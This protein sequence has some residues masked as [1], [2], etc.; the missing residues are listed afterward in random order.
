MS[1]F[2]PVSEPLI[3]LDDIN[4][5]QKVL[6]EGWASGEG[7]Y[8]SE[9]EDKMSKL[10]KRTQGISVSNGTAAL[11]ILIHSLNLG[12]GDEVILPSFTIISCLTQ[13][14]RSGATPIFVDS[15]AQTW[16]MDVDE[17][18]NSI[19][20]RTKLIIL[21]HIYGLPV[22][23]DPILK[24]AEDLGIPVIEDAAEAHGLTYKGEP[25]GSFGLAS[26]F[27]FFANK[28]ITTGEGG[29]V[30]TN[31]LALGQ[32]LK[33]L[34]N[35]AHHPAQ[36]FS[37]EVL[38]WNLRMTA[39]QCALGTSQLVRLDSILKKRNEIARFYREAFETFDSVQLPLEKT[40]YAVNNYWVF[41]MV[42]SPDKFESSKGIQQSLNE[43]G[44]GSR[45]FFQP[46]H[47]QPLLGHFGLSKQR[48][49]P[50]S[51]YLGRYGFYIPNG[52][53]ISDY[54]LNTVAEKVGKLIS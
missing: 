5:V 12:P 26:T 45:P 17:V 41:G 35:L 52:L 51:E 28:N 24:V 7:P 3:T 6:T 33:S 13:I 36:R 16:N 48:P 53:G 39:Y 2:I 31:D 43:L 19:T 11:E 50:N 46:L 29:M 47:K 22:D 44:I 9:F 38:G 32:Q 18:V 27:S 49:L 54:Q 23:M 1:S 25:C 8:V 4:Y 10:C 30:L 40:E 15:D 21:V 14:L 37:H 20:E 34:K 42:L